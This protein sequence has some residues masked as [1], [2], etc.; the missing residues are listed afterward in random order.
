MSFER[1]HFS[2]IN[3]KDVAATFSN[4]LFKESRTESDVNIK[5]DI[6]IYGVSVIFVFYKTGKKQHEIGYWKYLLITAPNEFLFA[7]FTACIQSI[8]HL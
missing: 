7:C 3:P 1:I 8:K 6:S 2:H 4:N 5:D